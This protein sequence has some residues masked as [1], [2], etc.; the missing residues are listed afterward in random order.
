MT[1]PENLPHIETAVRDAIVRMHTDVTFTA[2]W[3][4]PR[5]SWCG[6]DMIDVWAV[7]DGD[8]DDLAPPTSPSL[9]T[10]IRDILWGMG[11]DAWP[12]LNLVARSD[13][14]DLQPATV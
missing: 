8:V 6:S 9:L 3:L 10:R 2:I 7:Y 14:G 4:E 5:K 11:V 1:N 12:S 13:A